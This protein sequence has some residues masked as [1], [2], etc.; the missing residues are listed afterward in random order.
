[1][2]LS[3]TVT[4]NETFP[5]DSNVTRAMLRNAAS[6]TVEVT[7]SVSDGDLAS[8]AAVA[9]E[10]LVGVTEGQILVG[11][12]TAHASGGS[13]KKIAA[14]SPSSNASVTAA[15]AITPS[16]ATITKAKLS[17]DNTNNI[18][19]GQDGLSG[20]NSADSVLVYDADGPT[21]DRLKRA[22]VSSLLNA[23]VSS[24]SQDVT[25]HSVVSTSGAST[26]TI[27]LTSN[28]VQVVEISNSA[29]EVTFQVSGAPSDGTTAANVQIRIKATF[30]SSTATLAFSGSPGWTFLKTAPTTIAA[31]KDAILAITAFNDTVIAGYSVEA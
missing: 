15:G 6:P 1:M 5:D 29:A 27:D 12:S 19:M 24:T 2:S 18:I 31:Q 8:G 23:G 22:T 10:K 13:N 3:V 11:S 20:V 4:P 17:A 16:D 28:P 9:L 30:A 14:V 7:G 21:G 26:V 25:T